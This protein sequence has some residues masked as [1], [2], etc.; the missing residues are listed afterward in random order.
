MRDLRVLIVCEHASSKFGG[1]AML[2][3][4]Y[5]LLLS[6]KLSHVFLLTHSRTR[7]DLATVPGIDL[8]RVYFIPDTSVQK[9]LHTVGRR[10]PH[11]IATITTGALIHLITQ[12]YQWRMAR[13]IIKEQGVEIVHEPAPVSPKCP[14]MMFAL[15][16]P[17]IIGPMNGGMSFPPPF[18]AMAG[19]M[20]TLLYGVMRFFSRIY[21]ILIPGKLLA[22]ALLVANQRTKEALPFPDSTKVRELVENA[23]FAEKVLPAANVHRDGDSI[24]VLYVGR[25]V[26]WKALDI[27][28]DAVAA[29]RDAKIRLTIVGEGPERSSLERRATAVAADRVTFTGAVAHDRIAEYYDQA[30]IFALPSVRECGGAVVLE[31][32]ARGLPVIATNWGGPADYVTTETGILIDPLSRAHLVTEFTRQIELLAADA[33]KRLKYGQAALEHIKKYFV[34]E[35][36]VDTV[37]AI[38]ESVAQP[39]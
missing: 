2:P 6:R 10:L 25:L 32:M 18:S 1:E 8:D 26:D 3:L 17:V 16:A 30:D 28:I 21:N 27:L 9:L 22:A 29:C 12:C 33:D 36:K 39:K 19:R 34:W 31:A 15:K 20:E 38:Y 4:N 14:S 35:K 11:R 23:V 13:R 7:N 37:M 24:T 5:F